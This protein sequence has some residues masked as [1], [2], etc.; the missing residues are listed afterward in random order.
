MARA[1]MNYQ[2]MDS[3]SVILVQYSYSTRLV[4]MVVPFKLS[5]SR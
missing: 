2:I 1:D 3:V 4:S 5:L